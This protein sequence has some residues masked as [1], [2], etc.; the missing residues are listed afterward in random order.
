MFSTRWTCVLLAG[1][2]AATVAVITPLTVRAQAQA[3]SE[4]ELDVFRNLTPEQQQQAMEALSGGRNGGMSSGGVLGGGISGQ[5]G[6]NGLQ[7]QEQQ[8]FE[9]QRRLNEQDRERRAEEEGTDYEPLIPRFKGDDTLIVEVDFHLRPRATEARALIMQGINP[10]TGL[11]ASASA[12]GQQPQQQLDQLG[13][14]VT[15]GSTLDSSSAA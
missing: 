8:E 4:Q 3:P 7:R 2:A 12:N 6:A 15:S 13:E 5:G 1:L 14:G 10:Q 11:P 9:R